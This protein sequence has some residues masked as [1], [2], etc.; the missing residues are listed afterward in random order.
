[1]PW[2]EVS[3]MDERREFVRLAMQEG[4]N[5]KSF[6][7]GSRSAGLLDTSGLAALLPMGSSRIVRVVRIGRHCG[8]KRRLRNGF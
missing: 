8:L 3:V 5:G 4:A 6:V 1:M 7:G 2:R